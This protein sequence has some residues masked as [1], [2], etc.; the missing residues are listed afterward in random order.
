MAPMVASTRRRDEGGAAAVELAVVLPLLLLMAFAII[1][2]ALYYRST[3]VGAA[4]ARDAA[5]YAAVGTPVTCTEFRSTVAT[6]LA[7]VQTGDV[8]VSRDYSSAVA[9]V[10]QGDDVTVVVAFDSADL[11][12]PFLPFIDDGRVTQRYTAR[13]EDVPDLTL[14]DCT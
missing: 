13:V 7:S 6:R 12:F 10:A 1:Q 8:T 3:L 4:A 11:D 2:Y 9:P 5:R 14:A